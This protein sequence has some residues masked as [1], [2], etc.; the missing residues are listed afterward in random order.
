[1]RARGV[2]GCVCLL[3]LAS[4]CGGDDPDDP[5][6]SPKATQYCELKCGCEDQCS[7]ERC[8]EDINR[9]IRSWEEDG[10]GTEYD[11]MLNCWLQDGECINDTPEDPYTGRFSTTPCRD[12]ELASLSC[13]L[14][15]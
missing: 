8:E 2:I 13:F 7:F 4:A 15:D 10:C 5:P 9:Y 14:N 6:G 1:M 3:L 12:L 11:Q